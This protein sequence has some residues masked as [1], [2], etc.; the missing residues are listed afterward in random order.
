MSRVRSLAVVC[1]TLIVTFASG[2]FDLSRAADSSKPIPRSTTATAVSVLT[3]HNDRQRTGANLLETTLTTDNVNVNQ[4]GKL[5]TRTVS[6]QVYAQ[7]LVA[8]NVS[9][10]GVGLRNLVY[11]A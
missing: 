1:L 7:P 4:F 10:A 6:G 9:L 2:P 5:F 11:V 3:Q 8:A